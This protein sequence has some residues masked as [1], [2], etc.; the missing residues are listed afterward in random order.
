MGQVMKNITVEAGLLDHRAYYGYLPI[1]VPW[2]DHRAGCRNLRTVYPALWVRPS[3]NFLD[4]PL[5]ISVTVSYSSV[6]YE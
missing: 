3:H 5:D 2:L 1:I 4:M 6:K